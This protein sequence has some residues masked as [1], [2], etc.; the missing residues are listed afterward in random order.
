MKYIRLIVLS[1][2]IIL[3]F[4]FFSCENP[5]ELADN[6]D[7]NNDYS[8]ITFEIDDEV[9]ACF[10]LTNSFRTGNETWYWN[11][12]NSTITT[13]NN[14]CEL[15]LDENLCR[16]AKIRSQEIVQSFSHTRPD[17]RSCFTVFDDLNI[18]AFAKGENIAAGYKSGSSTFNQWKED[19]ENYS[20]QGHRRNM[21]G[22]FTK[23][24]LAYTYEANS[25]YR[26]YW[27][28]ILAK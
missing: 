18:T 26:Y 7:S 20:G 25:T 24:G 27:V 22:D 11:Q 19:N 2:C 13:L 15:T 28:M 8:N 12:D 4:T 6:S 10:N 16:A 23:I 17:G 1:F 3:S 5:P 21:L 9:R 14:L